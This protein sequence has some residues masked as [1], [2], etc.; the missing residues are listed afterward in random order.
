V[1]KEERRRQVFDGKSTDHR[2]RMFRLEH[3]QLGH[4]TAITMPVESGI[5]CVRLTGN[6]WTR[7]Y[8]ADNPS[9]EVTYRDIP[10]GVTDEDIEVATWGEKT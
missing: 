2:S 7:E 3:N 4:V 10:L 6:R 9:S 8:K 5:Y 1:T